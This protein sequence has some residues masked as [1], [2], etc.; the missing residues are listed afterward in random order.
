V[1]R[2]FACNASIDEEP[3]AALQKGHVQ[4]LFQGRLEKELKSLL[5]GNEKLSSHGGVKN[6][7]Y[8]IPSG[9][10]EIELKRGV[11]SKNKR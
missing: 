8:N 2:R 10:I 5:T 6:S 4:V 11:S 3:V 1:S 7:S 9:V